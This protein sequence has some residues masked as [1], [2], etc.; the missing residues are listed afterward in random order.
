MF[1]GK[2]VYSFIGIYKAMKLCTYLNI[3]SEYEGL[4]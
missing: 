4:R 1:I 3:Y 2:Y